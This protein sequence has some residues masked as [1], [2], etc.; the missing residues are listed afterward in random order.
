ML[1]ITL[2][3]II[4]TTAWGWKRGMMG[5]M[6]VA[7]IDVLEEE[8]VWFRNVRMLSCCIVLFLLAVY[9]AVLMWKG[10]PKL[11]VTNLM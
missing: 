9:V 10:I 8:Y 7:R 6:R 1:E 11:D 3:T 2:L 5:A 4:S